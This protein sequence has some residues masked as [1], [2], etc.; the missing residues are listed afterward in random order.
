MLVWCDDGLYIHSGERHDK[1]NT[2]HKLEEFDDRTI[3]QIC[4]SDDYISIYC[5]EG[6]FVARSYAA[7]L[8]KISFIQFDMRATQGMSVKIDEWP[9][10]EIGGRWFKT[11]WP[12]NP[13]D[14]EIQ[15]IEFESIEFTPFCFDV[16]HE[17]Q[18]QCRIC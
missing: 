11:K 4:A 6:L 10:I 14:G 1:Q 3:F 2:F 17:A 13:M 12:S 18:S 8:N 9:F 7:S 15:T 16:E 5:A